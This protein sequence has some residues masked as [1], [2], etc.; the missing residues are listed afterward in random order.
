MCSGNNHSEI[1]YL[2]KE[3]TSLK[4]ENKR[5]Q[6]EIIEIKNNTQEI[7]QLTNYNDKLLLK[8]TNYQNL[9]L[10]SLTTIA[11]SNNNTPE[12][13]TGRIITHL[14]LTSQFL[15]LY[16]TIGGISPHGITFL[17]T[18]E[19]L[20]GT[21]VYDIKDYD[22]SNNPIGYNLSYNFNV[23]KSGD[24]IPEYN[25]G[26][27]LAEFGVNQIWSGF[28]PELRDTFDISCVPAGIGNLL[29]DDGQICRDI[30]VNLSL[31]AGYTQQQSYNYNVGCKIIPPT[32]TAIP[33]GNLQTVSITNPK[34]PFT[35]QVIGFPLDTA[36]P[37]Q[38][39]G[40]ASGNYNVEW[41]NPIVSLGN[42]KT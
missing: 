22:I 37:K 7:Y 6:K 8:N 25:A 12:M 20:I 1:K 34:A 40:Y 30:A 3:I 16:V 14:N 5:Q 33:S 29:C 31:K 21:Y 13:K 35:S 27:T 10:R 28:V 32:K 17:K 42:Y 39:T 24:P 23:L 19:P 18:L 2:K 11:N 41:I 9:N 15:D 38:Q 26:P 4:K 36:I